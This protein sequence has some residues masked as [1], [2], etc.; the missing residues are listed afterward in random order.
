LPGLTATPDSRTAA[1][2]Y[3]IAL[4]KSAEDLSA[5]VQQCDYSG[6]RPGYLEYL[7]SYSIT[8]P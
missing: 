3:G 7:R 6:L 2:I 1:D 8:G 5:D 4:G